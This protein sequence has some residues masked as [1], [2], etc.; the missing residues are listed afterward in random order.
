M[1]R[2]Q[3]V[4]SKTCVSHTFWTDSKEKAGSMAKHLHV[5]GYHNVEVWEHAKDGAHKTDL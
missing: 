4:F 3:V 5:A 1:S 2:Y